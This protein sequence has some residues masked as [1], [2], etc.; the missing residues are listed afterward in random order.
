MTGLEAVAIAEITGC[1]VTS[2]GRHAVLQASDATGERIALAIPEHLL[3]GL[4]VAFASASGNSRRILGDDPDAMHLFSVRRFQTGGS[5][6]GDVAVAFELPE[7][8]EVALLLPQ[9]LAQS[10][11]EALLSA[12]GIQPSSPAGKR[13]H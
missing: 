2:D 5:K 4:I 11:G 6:Q 1:N 9:Q 13:S 7:G 3:A 10:L 12:S 8:A